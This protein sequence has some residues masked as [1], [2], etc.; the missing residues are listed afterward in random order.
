MLFQ[1]LEKQVPHFIFWGMDQRRFLRNL[2]NKLDLNERVFL[3]SF[4]KNLEDWLNKSD[5]HVMTSLYEGSPNVLWEASFYQSL[6]S[7]FKY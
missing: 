5:I 1:K 6:N 4:R 7:L 2:I 3:I